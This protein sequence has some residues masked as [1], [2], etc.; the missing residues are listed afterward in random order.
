MATSLYRKYRHQTWAQVTNQNHVKVT[1]QEEIIRG[2]VAHAYLFAG[3]RGIGKTTTARIMAKALNCETRAKNSAEPCDK[4]R[5]CEDIREGRSLDL[6]EIDAA[7]NTGTMY[8]SHYCFNV[9][10]SSL[11]K[12]FVSMRSHAFY[13]VYY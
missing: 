12:I 5:S 13:C 3:P 4:C 2:R 8:V 1:L 10:H 11:Y 6:I 9:C 7:S